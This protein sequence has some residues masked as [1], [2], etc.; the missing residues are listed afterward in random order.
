[1]TQAELYTLLETLGLP[2]AYMAFSE[3][4]DPPFICYTFQY[5]QDLM[6]DNKNDV[7][8]DFFHV[9]F[10][11]DKKDLTNEAA[12]EALFKA[13]KMPYGKSEVW[14]DSEKLIEIIYEIQLTN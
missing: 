10:Y 14:I 5:N 1:M 6:A 11:A 9:E 8:L 13:N 12:I 7:S 2:V 4:T 3:Q